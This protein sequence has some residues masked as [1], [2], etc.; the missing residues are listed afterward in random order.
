VNNTDK[1]TDPA[2]IHTVDHLIIRDKDTGKV[3]VN[4]RDTKGNLE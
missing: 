3:I 2:A 4:K 1:K